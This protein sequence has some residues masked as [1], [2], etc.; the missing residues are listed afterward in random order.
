MRIIGGSLGGRVLRPS[1]KKWP[2]RPT[3]D[4]AKEALY[5]ILAHKIDLEGIRCLDLFGGAGNHSLEL[6]S[7]GAGH[8]TYVDQYHGCVKWMREVTTKLSLNQVRIERSEVRKF[9]QQDMDKYDLIFADP[10]YALSWLSELPGLILEKDRLI[11]DGILV[12]EH[13]SQTNL[14][15]HDRCTDRR[16]YGQSAFSFFK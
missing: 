8:V 7:R 14:D 3:T 5:N 10:P 2:T 15:H 9:L 4:I 6:A 13:A 1:M 12:I 16:K 11:E